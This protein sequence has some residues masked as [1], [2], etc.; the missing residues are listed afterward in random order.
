[1]MTNH[2]FI[3]SNKI[4]GGTINM[5]KKSMFVFIILLSNI[6]N[7][8]VSTCPPNQGGFIHNGAGNISNVIDNQH[9]SNMDMYWCLTTGYFNYGGTSPLGWFQQYMSGTWWF[10]TQW[11]TPWPIGCC[12]CWFTNFSSSVMIAKLEQN[13]NPGTAAHSGEC[14][15]ELAEQ[16]LGPQ[17]E[18]WF[19]RSYD[20]P[21]SPLPTF[22]ISNHHSTGPGGITSI[23]I[24]NWG[25]VPG[26]AHYWIKEYNGPEGDDLPLNPKCSSNCSGSCPEPI[27]GYEIRAIAS[28]NPPTTELASNWNLT[29]TNGII[30]PRIPNFPF[31]IQIQ[32]PET[33]NSSNRYIFIATRINLAQ[34]ISTVL[35]SQNSVAIDWCMQNPSEAGKQMQCQKT[36]G[37]SILCTYSNGGTCASDSTIYYGSLALVSSYGYS[38]AACLLGTSGNVS[39]DPGPG[40]S[41][42]VIV[43]NNGTNEGSYGKNSNGNERPEAISVGSCDYPQNLSNTC[44]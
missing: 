4:T 44:Q 18:F 27:S 1:M 13:R 31:T 33:C 41:F 24:D 39:F 23:T 25:T 26:P 14:T 11:M 20:R 42:W 30:T 16:N 22:H 21:F 5:T 6:C 37:T 15:V 9:I 19:T 8:A 7:L 28:G 2:I 29:V 34:N 35:I 12:G 38:G 43:S 17:G 3:R 36:A 32:N 10:N 40:D